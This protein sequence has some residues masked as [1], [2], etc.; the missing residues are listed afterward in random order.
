MV[1]TNGTGLDRFEYVGQVGQG[2]GG[3]SPYWVGQDGNGT[4]GS[5]DYVGQGRTVDRSLSR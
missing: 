4:G 2:E 1:Q 5:S 3:R